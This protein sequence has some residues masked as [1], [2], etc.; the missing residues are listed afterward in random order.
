VTGTVADA[1]DVVFVCT[2]NRA[3]SVLA[4]ALFRRYATGIDTVVSSVGTDAVTAKPALASGV[5]AAR[6]LGV[7]LAPHKARR[8][9]PGSLR[10]ADLVLGFEQEHVAAAVVEGGASRDRAFLLGEI[11][12]L[13]DAVPSGLDPPARARAA[14]RRAHMRRTGSAHWPGT[15]FVADPAGRPRRVMFRTAEAIDELVRALVVGLF[16]LDPA[17]WDPGR[18]RR[19]LRSLRSRSRPS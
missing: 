2:A 17:T 15:R 16:A 10:D 19:G 12:L 8:L 13:L 5:E 7:D 11:V 9:R 14:V 1:F 18:G 4:E 3:R 6:R